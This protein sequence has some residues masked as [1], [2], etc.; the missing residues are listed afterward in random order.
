MRLNR[1]SF[2]A[3]FAKAAKVANGR[4][5]EILGNVLVESDGTYVRITGYNGSLMVTAKLP[6]ESP[7]GKLLLPSDRISAILSECSDEEI[8]F[9]VQGTELLVKCGSA[10][11][12]LGLLNALEYP[13]LTVDKASATLTVK[14]VTLRTALQATEF[15]VDESST[16]YQLGGVAFDL[17]AN[18]IECVAT[19]GRRLSVF[20]AECTGNNAGMYIVPAIV[21]RTLVSLLADIEGDI[22]VDMSNG[23]ITVTAESLTLKASLIDGRYPN[24]KQVMPNVSGFKEISIRAKEFFT[25]VRQAS[26]TSDRETRGMLIKIADGNVTLGSKAEIGSSLVSFLVSYSEEPV[27]LTLDYKYLSDFLRVMVPEDD[28]KLLVGSSSQPAMLVARD[29]HRYVIMPMAKT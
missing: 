9:E 25:A 23:W 29:R 20:E 6:S 3:A 12:C 16:R 21:C 1:E 8:S 17:S 5:K 27:E 14:A 24:W 13:G 26:I 22:Q 19:D 18:S 10:K 2:K 7:A 28:I 11:F 4:V 15:A